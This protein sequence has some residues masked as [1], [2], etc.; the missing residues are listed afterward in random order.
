MKKKYRVLIII[1]RFVLSGPML[2][3]AL[4]AKYLEPEFETL[5]IGGSEDDSE[6]NAEYIFEEM[7]VKY[8]KIDE[9]KRSVNPFLDYPAYI[10]LRTIIADFKPDIVHT[11]AAK[12]GAVGRYAAM[13][14]KVPVILHTFHGHVFHSYFNPIKTQV[15][16][17]IERYLAKKSSGI[18]A[19]SNQQKEELANDFHICP[20]DKIDVIPLGFE[21]SIFT[22]NQ[23]QK[24]QN[25]REEFSIP[26]LTVAVAIIG[27]IA[28][29]KNHKLFVEAIPLIMSKAIHPCKFF[30]VG[31]GELRLEIEN[32]AQKM[33]ISIS[34]PEH[35]DTQATLVLTSWRKDI[36]S[37]VAGMDIIALTSLNEGTPATLIEAQAAKKP[38]V[39]TKV[40]GIVDIV[41]EG[42]SALLSPS[43]EVLPF[44]E[45]TVRLINDVTLREQMAG[46]G[47][48]YII[49]NFS[50]QRLIND[51]STL[52]NSLLHKC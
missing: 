3:A 26:T 2:Q 18:I 30:I 10:K 17:G 9:M 40:G 36:D 48:D 8:L 44:A 39:S 4:M 43:N 28:P 42:K 6:A 5:L 16:I 29:I 13:R 14:A 34:T 38:I 21:F 20:K 1:H 50:Y 46:Q 15:F 27:R 49:K 45:N 22:E 23:E 25:I 7:G 24:R 51:L 19:I 37:I 31:D 11:H 35:I 47:H 12:A 32:Q 52:Y 33:G 41:Y